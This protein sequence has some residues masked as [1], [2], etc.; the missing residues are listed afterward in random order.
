MTTLNY[1]STH[2]LISKDRN[3]YHETN[4]LSILCRNYF[5]LKSHSRHFGSNISA[6]A[7]PGRNAFHGNGRRQRRK[8]RVPMND[9][10]NRRNTFA[11]P[12][13]WENQSQEPG[14]LATCGFYFIGQ[15]DITE[16]YS[17]KL[18]L[19]GWKES[20]DPF[21]RHFQASPNCTYLRKDHFGMILLHCA[22]EFAL[23]Q[24]E[25]ARLQSF[26]LEKWPLDYLIS[27]EELSRAGFFPTGKRNC[28]Q[29]FRC[30]CLRE[31]WHK[32]ESALAVHRSLSPD[33]PFLRTLLHVSVEPKVSSP[34]KAPD[35]SLLQTRLRS[36]KHFKDQPVDK[37]ELAKSGFY[38]IQP[39]SIVKCYACNII[40]AGFAEGE[41][42][43]KVHI[44]LSPK[45]PAL[46]LSDVEASF[47]PQRAQSEPVPMEV[48]AHQPTTLL[49][50][51]PDP[52]CLPP[53]M[54]SEQ[55]LQS[56][57]RPAQAKPFPL[58][59]GVGPSSVYHPPSKSFNSSLPSKSKEYS[60]EPT[61]KS[62]DPSPAYEPS[63]FY[64]P[65][66]ASNSIE[67]MIYEPPSKLYDPS[68]LASKSFNPSLVS[69]GVAVSV[70]GAQ[71]SSS[72]GYY[73]PAPLSLQ[74]GEEDSLLNQQIYLPPS[75]HKRH[76]SPQPMSLPANTYRRTYTPPP[77]AAP[78]S[79]A[80]NPTGHNSSQQCIICFVH[81]KEYAILPCGHLCSCRDCAKQLQNCP[82]CRTRKN[83]MVKIFNV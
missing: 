3:H 37:E 5:D 51:P 80:A 59:N 50:P 44:K 78:A 36:F 46:K 75:F 65:S 43:D 69:G 26:I 68:P 24:E 52:S 61:L 18:R 31:T 17:C 64:D 33:C 10:D 70:G 74:N 21:V 83:G 63:N 49:S 81:P 38:L 16:C 11:Y 55:D 60:Y 4:F 57:F 35:Y 41:L 19:F 8:G 2:C 62:F 40:V 42:P 13:Q 20:Q 12:P 67:P 72:T 76:A 45:C 73:K 28:I 48:E 39:P 58:T 30:G 9:I 29:C 79:F 14:I 25:K 6:S 32:G 22:K 7:M 54:I 1:R 15:E 27:Y 71:P 53:P 47:V 77:H 82:V 23:F 56:M 34:L 66:P